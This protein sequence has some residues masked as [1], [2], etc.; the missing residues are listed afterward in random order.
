LLD[1]TIDFRKER[2]RENQEKM[3]KPNWKQHVLEEE[4]KESKHSKRFKTLNGVSDDYVS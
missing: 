3:G 2:R 4:R 1:I